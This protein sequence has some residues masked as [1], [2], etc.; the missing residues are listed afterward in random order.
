MWA[1]SGSGSA[2]A[3]GRESV[4]SSCAFSVLGEAARGMLVREGGAGEAARR[5]ERERMEDSAEGGGGVSGF[6]HRRWFNGDK[7]AGEE[8]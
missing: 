5:A 1:V 7:S 2:E 3:I 4:D 8:G 6:E